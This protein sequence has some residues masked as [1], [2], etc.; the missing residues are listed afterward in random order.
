M[1]GTYRDAYNNLG[2]A[3]SDLGD[4]A[5]AVQAYTQAIAIDPH[6]WHA[7]NN[8]GLALWA[9]RRQDEALRDY[10]KVKELLGGTPGGEPV[11]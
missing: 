11:H 1:D 6:D 8:R 2:L 9:L 10:A 3:L 5:A 7:Y 4:F